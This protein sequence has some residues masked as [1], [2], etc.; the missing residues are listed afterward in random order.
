MQRQL[1]LLP[2]VSIA[3]GMGS[4]FKMLKLESKYPMKDKCY[5][6]HDGLHLKRLLM[7]ATL[8]SRYCF[9]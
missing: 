1:N 2:I 6:Q 4:T 8:W 7:L 9:F 5:S 3:F